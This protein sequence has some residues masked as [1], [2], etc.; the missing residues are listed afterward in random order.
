MQY[1]NLEGI[2]EFAEENY[3]DLAGQMDSNPNLLYHFLRLYVKDNQELKSKIAT[4]TYI[5]AKLE[6]ELRAF[7]NSEHE[8]GVDESLSSNPVCE[9]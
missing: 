7:S 8:A 5:V 2:T 9:V 1:D 4:L 3:R 6:F